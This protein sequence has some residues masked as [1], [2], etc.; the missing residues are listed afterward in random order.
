MDIL[1][2]KILKPILFFSI[3]IFFSYESEVHAAIEGNL[4]NPNIYPN[5]IISFG[6]TSF[7]DSLGVR[8]PYVIK[9][10][11]N[12]Y[13]YYD[14]IEDFINPS[15]ENNLTTNGWETW[16]ASMESSNVRSYAG[17]RS[18]LVANDGTEN[19][20]AFTGKYYYENIRDSS[21]IAMPSGLEVVPNKYYVVSGY[22]WAESGVGATL[23]VKQYRNDPGYYNE[24]WISSADSI[25]RQT[26]NGNWQRIYVNLLTLP[27]TRAITISLIPDENKINYWDAIQMEQVED[28][29]KAPSSF[30]SSNNFNLKLE[31][32]IGWRPCVATSNDGIN[33]IKRGIVEIIGDQGVWEINGINGSSPL[34]GPG[35]VGPTVMYLSPFYH[36]GYWYSYTWQAPGQP[37][38]TI[39][40]GQYQMPGYNVMRQQLPTANPTRSGLVR[41]TNP[42]G[43][44]ERISQ[45]GPMISPNTG[46]QWGEQYIAASG[47]P[48]FINNIWTLF[49]SGQELN[50]NWRGITPGI[51]VSNSRLGPWQTTDYSP[52]LPPDNDNIVP[53]GPIYY[54]DRSGKHIIFI[55]DI[56]HGSLIAY[57]ADNPFSKWESNNRINVITSS[58]IPWSPGLGD[59]SKAIGLSSVIEKDQ[60]TLL[61]YFAER[62]LSVKTPYLFHN[63]GLI[64]YN[65]PLIIN[66]DTTPPA[67]PTNVRVQ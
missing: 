42:L 14:C 4:N 38:G 45:S 25:I 65:L 53:E 2:N 39:T 26:G 40:D 24:N 32:S 30:P 58:Q 17:Q 23:M 21:H 33:Y 31:N 1:I 22:F 11:N 67:V 41:A 55:N 59:G 44:F 35:F 50:Y 34:T 46:T 56:A 49:L 19:G 64:I 20:G 18:L 29:S 66:T 47:E 13:L 16:G 3:F 28:I 10:Q 7:H 61:A 8:D 5:P 36:N 12:Y 15:F 60:N 62:D 37:I 9:N 6:N 54:Y 63:I 57:W 43:P 52:I 51:A 48:R 27:E